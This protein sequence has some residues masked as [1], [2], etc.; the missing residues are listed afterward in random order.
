MEKGKNHK[1]T[2]T[3]VAHSSH[4][5]PLC[6]VAVPLALRGVGYKPM[7]AAAI[8]QRNLLLYGVGGILAPFPGIWIIDRLLVLLHLA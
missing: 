3:N 4:L 5:R 1:A 2:V 7:G 6:G 8:L